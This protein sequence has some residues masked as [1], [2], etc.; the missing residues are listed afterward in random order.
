MKDYIKIDSFENLYQ[1]ELKKDILKS[2]EIDAF[3][4]NKRDNMFLIGNIEL[5]TKKEDEKKAKLLLEQFYGLTK[6]NSFVVLKPILL[7][8]KILQNADIEC[9]IKTKENDKY[10]LSNYEL[11]VKN[12]DTEKVRPYL[13]GEKL[14]DYIKI[15]TCKRVRQV[16]LYNTILDN[17]KVFLTFPS[18]DASVVFFFSFFFLSVEFVFFSGIILFP[19]Y[20]QPVI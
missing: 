6:I 5:Y 10:L 4:V 17:C 9:T 2:N 15:K 18:R 8:Q 20:L 13:T 19:E 1:A 14:E 7:F 12:E 3:V 16:Q 11:Y